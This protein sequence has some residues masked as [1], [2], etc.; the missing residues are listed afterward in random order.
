MKWLKRWKTR[1]RFL[2]GAI[3]ASLDALSIF[4][5]WSVRAK[6]IPPSFPNVELPRRA[7]P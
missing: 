1:T 7:A 2:L 5:H 6:L 4:A 3:A